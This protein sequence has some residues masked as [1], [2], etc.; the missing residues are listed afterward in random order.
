MPDIQ[1]GPKLN[2]TGAIKLVSVD[3]RETNRCANVRGHII[4][5]ARL[6]ETSFSEH[7][8]PPVTM[9]GPVLFLEELTSK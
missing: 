5:I 6:R 8:F 9:H 3:S 1:L 2:A 7:G 4:G